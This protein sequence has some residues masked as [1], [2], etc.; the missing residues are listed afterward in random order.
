MRLLVVSGSKPPKSFSL[1]RYCR[2]AAHPPG[3]GLPRQAPSVKTSTSDSSDI[4][5]VPARIGNGAVE[6]QLTQI[7][8]RILWP[9]QYPR[10]W[11][12]PIKEP[13]QQ[14]AQRATAGEHRQ[15]SKFVRR[16]GPLPSITVEQQS[17]LGHIKAAVRFEAPGVEADRQVIGKKISAGEIEVNQAGQ[18]VVAEEYVIRKK[19]G[20]DYPYREVTRPHGLEQH[21]FG[22]EFFGE[23]RLCLG[24]AGPTGFE[25]APPAGDREI[26]R[27]GHP[28]RRAGPVQFG[29]R[30]AECGAM[31]RQ[32][33]PRAHSGEKRHDR[34][35]PPTQ[36]TQG[37]AVTTRHRRRACDAVPREMLHQRD[38]ERQ[39]PRDDPL[40]VEGQN[41][42]AALGGEQKV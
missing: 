1:P 13:R 29:E 21:K 7:F 20:V 40:F 38:K 16:E 41:E 26:I 15:R 3:P 14:K 5:A 25:E 33:S 2:I 30:P 24:G 11:V 22:S 35:G 28:E 9:D 12:K 10:R 34:R 31:E 39:V 37:D 36:L 17:C 23:P 18:R 4:E 42:I 19:V 8:E 32:N 27:S 6:P